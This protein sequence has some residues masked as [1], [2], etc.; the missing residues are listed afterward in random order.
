MIEISFSYLVGLLLD[1]QVH[2]RRVACN[3]KAGIC[4]ARGDCDCY[5]RSILY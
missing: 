4:F 2:M 1:V 3:V 5:I